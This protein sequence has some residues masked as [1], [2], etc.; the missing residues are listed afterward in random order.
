MIDF[1]EAYLDAKLAL[2]LFY[3]HTLTGNWKEAEKAAKTTE[4]MART[5]Q[6]LAKENYDKPV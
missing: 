5:L 3:K 1:S 4:E 2:N 6:V